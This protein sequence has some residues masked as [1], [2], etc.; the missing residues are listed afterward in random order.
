MEV[1]YLK[2]S[3]TARRSSYFPTYIVSLEENIQNINK[4][5]F[6]TNVV[7]QDDVFLGYIIY[8]EV[9]SMS[10]ETIKSIFISSV[11]N[12]ASKIS[13]YVVNPE[14]DLTRTKKLPAEKLL[15]FL[16]S[17]GSSNTTNELLDFFDFKAEAP[18]ASA[19]NQQ[20]AKL[21]SDAL[22]AVFNDFNSSVNSMTKPEKYRFLAAD[23]STFTF[24]SKPTFAS[25]EYYVADGHSA[26]GFYSMHLNALYDLDNHIYLDALTQPVHSKNEF[27]AF[28]DMVDRCKTPFGT[29]DVYIGDRGY[30]SYN[31][32]AHVVEKEQYFLF[33]TKDI[34]SK[35][36]VSNFDF[37]NQ[38]SFDLNVKVTLTRS[39]SK[40]IN[41]TDSYRR[42]IGK[43]ITFDFIE[44]GSLDTYELSFRVVRFPISDSSFECILTNLPN[45]EFPSE[46]IKKLYISRW[47]IESSFRKLKYTI[48]LANFHS[49]KPEYIKQEIW[50]KLVAYNLTEIIIANTIIERNETKYDYEINFSVAAHI[51]RIFIRSKSE[52]SNIDVTSLLQKYLFP[53]R[54]DR[55]FSR[56]QSAHFRRPR[57]FQYR[58]A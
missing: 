19:L 5:I 47:G 52:K 9:H 32:M 13:G 29:K 2:S 40:K 30:S 53:I 42:F 45:E 7:Y 36:L 55:E 41:C 43:K 16:V 39:N 56:L 37:P 12:I 17:Q 27:S 4:N 3:L 18:T 28:C 31:N 25:S 58:S 20:R 14:K 34:T 49:Y 10:P 24:L 51:C 46:K 6:I 15:T 26:K 23:G 21:K 57:Y 44:Y 35:G 22:E 11:E 33:R 48:G 50:A 1:T 54:N 8:E 38:E